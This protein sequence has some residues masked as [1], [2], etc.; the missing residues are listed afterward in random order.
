MPGKVK[1]DAVGFCGVDDSVEDPQEIVKLSALYPF[2]EWGVLFRPGYE[3][4]PRHPTPEYAARLG[5]VLKEAGSVRVAAH[6]CFEDAQ[7]V[8]RGEVARV[9]EVL[10]MLGCQRMQVNV[11]GSPWDKEKGI[12]GLLKVLDSFPDVEF[13]LQTT[14]RVQDEL[15]PLLL[16]ASPRRTNLAVLYDPSCGAGQQPSAWPAPVPG[17]HCGYAGGLGPQRIV[18]Q[19]QGLANQSLAGYDGAVWIDMESS[20]RSVRPEDGRDIFDLSKVK[21]V[22]S[23]VTDESA[24]ATIVPAALTST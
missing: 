17:V 23:K 14:Q 20:L 7:R 21:D 9:Q 10:S 5:S 12:D 13:I 22:I 2:I 16:Q 18:A 3:G 4:T 11:G 1:L 8:M 19:L 24:D 6:M 15:L